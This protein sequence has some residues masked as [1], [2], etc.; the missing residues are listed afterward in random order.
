MK[1]YSQ[2]NS[3]LP[4]ENQYFLYNSYQ[5]KTIFLEEELKELLEAAIHEGIDNLKEVHPSFFDY[6]V[7]SGF[8]VDSSFDEVQQVKDISK[9]ID[10]NTDF[11]LLT[12]NPTMNCNFKCWYCYETH[13][14][15]SKLG[16]SVLDSIQSFITKT[17]NK[18][19]IK[20]FSL[21]FFGGEPLLY[22]EKNVKPLVEHL[23][24]END[25]SNKMIHVSFTTN[26]YLINQDFID[27]F[28]SV[29]IKPHLQ[30]TLDGYKDEHDKV[31]FVSKKKGSYDEIVKNIIFLANN[32]FPVN[33]RINFT[34]ENLSNSSKIVEDFKEVSEE[35]K[36]KYLKFDFH[37]V[38]QNNQIDDLDKTL[39][40]IRAQFEIWG[41]RTNSNNSPNNIQNSCYADKRN[42]ATINYNGD[43][44]KCTARDFL[45]ENR[46]GYLSEEGDL[47]WENDY[48]ERRMEA[49]FS[50]KPCLSCRIMPLCNGG[51]SQHAMEYKEA[52]D[53]YCIYQG[54]ENEKSKIVYT[55]VEEIIN[56][57]LQEA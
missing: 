22:F 52:N 24:R 27:Y 3:L 32:E 35:A 53:E 46:G 9:K 17:I 23:K 36:E 21:A 56:A 49:K 8:V 33:V 29:D 39:H 6:L 1:K 45:T 51:C 10:E 37:R 12:V 31:R 14:K 2:F 15:D 19:N 28:N 34:D 4:Y 54:D 18:E 16:S 38:W 44:F 25:H 5:Q 13:I 42:S 30:I 55:K 57:E 47:I 41:L 11:F 50:N 26:G 40:E 7:E 20:F 48:L 43:L